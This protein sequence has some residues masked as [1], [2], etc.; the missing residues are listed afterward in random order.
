[1][2][3]QA[4]KQG[5]EGKDGDL[6][7]KEVGKGGCF[8]GKRIIAAT[9]R[10]TKELLGGRGGGGQGVAAEGGRGKGKEGR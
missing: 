3:L 8:P 1:M 9:G 4:R 6:T 10:A 7:L 2:S 5:G